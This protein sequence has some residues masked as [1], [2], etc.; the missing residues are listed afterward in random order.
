MR[1][2]PDEPVLVVAGRR[3]DRRADVAR[4]A[5]R[6]SAI[7]GG[8]ALTARASLRRAAAPTSS[9]SSRCPTR[10]TTPRRSRPSSRRRRSGSSTTG[11]ARNIVFVTHEGDIV[12]HD[13]TVTEWERANTSMSL[14]DGV[15]PYG[16]GPGNHDQPTTLYNQYFPYTRF[17]GRPWYGGHYQDKNDNNYPAV[18]RRRHGLRHRPP[19]VLSAGRRRCVG[20]RRCSRRIRTAS[21]S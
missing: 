14:L 6:A 16:M 3:R 4:A 21:A 8:G 11:R 10:S 17:Q 2:A 9:R 7:P 5:R 12:E 1:S 20:R 13:S 19:G 18:L 15:M